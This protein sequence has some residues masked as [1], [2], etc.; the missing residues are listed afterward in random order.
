MLKSKLFVFGRSCFSAVR[1]GNTRKVY[2]RDRQYLYLINKVQFLFIPA[3]TR[4]FLFLSCYGNE[5]ELFNS[6]FVGATEGNAY[7]FARFRHYAKV[8]LI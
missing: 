1:F 5:I 6:Q 8:L 7:I 4:Y 3:R 2:E